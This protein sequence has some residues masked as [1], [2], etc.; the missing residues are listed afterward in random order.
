MKA[1]WYEKLGPADKVLQFGEMPDPDPGPGE[2]LVKLHTSGV[3][4]I[5]VK[6]RMGARGDMAAPRIVPHFDGAGVIEA[7][8][9]GVQES[10][11]GERV[12]I[13]GAQW[14]REFGT[15][16]ERI[17]LPEKQA[18][19]LPEKA[20]FDD[21]A[22]LGIPALTAYGAVFS[23]G[24]VKG[25]TVMV[26]GGAGAV[27]RYAVQFAKL[28]G[29]ET[30]ATVSSDEK[31]EIAK[32]AGASHVL[33]YRQ[34]DVAAKVAEITQGNGIDLIVEVEFGGN[35][36][37]SIACLKTGGTIASYASQAVPE[38]TLPFYTLMYN[39]IV[40]RH[41]LV[42]RLSDSVIEQAITDIN[43]WMESGELTH[44]VGPRFLLAETVA[45]HQ[46]LEAGAVGK[47]LVDV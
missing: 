21:G 45:A 17:A 29:A 12:W 44:H 20:S 19:P 4:P 16:A 32:S 36:P 43:R 46:A 47:V 23:D 15:A 35:L 31:A 10:R 26:T 40:L 39:A 14:E 6:V 24:S 3:N 38:P 37:T 9:S 27:G 25:K 22:C 34:Q 11:I 42:F 18:V 8:G 30:I 2:V 5:D 13:Y 33:N 7:V 1:V 41:V 28:G